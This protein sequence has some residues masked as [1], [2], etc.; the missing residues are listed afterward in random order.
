[1]SRS[2]KGYSGYRGRRTVTDILK[3]TAV[4]LAV[5]VV[6]ALGVL[7]LAQD[8]L[9]YTDGGVRWNLPF[10]GRE[11]PPL[12]DPGEVSVTETVPGGPDS[13][14]ASSSV[15]PEEEPGLALQLPVS[16]LTGGS[17]AGELAA[18]GAQALI[19]EMKAPDGTLAWRSGQSLASLAGVNGDGSGDAALEQWLQGE[20]YTVARVCCFRDDSIPYYDTSLAL[21]RGEGNWRDELGLRWM[22]PASQRARDY[23]AALCGEL[24]AMGFE[25]IV[26]E[27]CAFPI[28]GEVAAINRGE[29][30]DPGLATG[31]VEA[32]L[33]QVEQAAAPY[34]T[35]V[36]LLAGR[37]TLAGMET[38][39]GLTAGVLEACAS[40]IWVEQ[41]GLEP[42]AE[43]LLAQAG[44]SGGAE[45]L[46]VLAREPE[47]GRYTARGSF[48]P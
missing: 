39:S 28:Q 17:A 25:E 5:V 16:S 12:P 45:R 48:S 42:E 33:K 43:Q 47:Q 31:Q 46:V 30:Y 14:S 32:F 44:V 15:Q 41:D 18:A 2:N 20:V 3:L 27:H 36:S 11:E 29:G 4:I 1:M 22:T 40:R 9:V 7:F 38:A 6:L 35:R 26:L 23:L 8:Y 10:L 24:A 21:R 13:S 34:G 37:D 19:L